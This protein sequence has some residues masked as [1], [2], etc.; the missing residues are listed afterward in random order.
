[1]EKHVWALTDEQLL[2]VPPNYAWAHHLPPDQLRRLIEMQ[3][4]AAM[5]MVNGKDG[6]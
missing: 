5:A 2:R 1:M 6:K 4:A 3:S